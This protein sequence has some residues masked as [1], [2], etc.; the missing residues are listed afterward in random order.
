MEFVTQY[1]DTNIVIDVLIEDMMMDMVVGLCIMC[2]GMIWWKGDK[3][4]YGG[5]RITGVDLDDRPFELEYFEDNQV[6]T[7]N[8]SEYKVRMVRSYDVLEYCQ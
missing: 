1:Q 2:G 3:K 4:W 8:D 7:H 5:R 6:L